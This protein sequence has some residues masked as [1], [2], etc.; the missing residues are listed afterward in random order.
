[1][2]RTTK[3]APVKSQL[4]R[5]LFSERRSLASESPIDGIDMAVIDPQAM[6]WMAA[7]R[8]ERMNELADN[9]QTVAI[10]TNK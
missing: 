3:D 1:M 8:G 9:D 7:I 4:G 6:R 2:G 10:V 5:R